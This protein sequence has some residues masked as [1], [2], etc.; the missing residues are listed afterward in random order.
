[1]PKFSTE[2]YL[3]LLLMGCLF[4]M[5]P[6]LS[7]DAG[8][9]GDEKVHMEQA[10]KVL[11][12]FASFSQ[13]KSAVHTPVTNLSHYG[14][15]VDNITTL[16]SEV[17]QIEDVYLF[18][19]LFNS[20]LAWLCVLFTAL[21][22]IH[23]SGYGAAMV[24]VLLLVLSPRF[25][26][27]SFNNLKD[28]PFAL[29][30]IASLYYMIKVN[31]YLPHIRLKDAVG[32]IFSMAFILS[33]RPGGL[34]VF[35]YFIG[36]TGLTF[37]R[38]M[39]QQTIAQSMWMIIAGRTLAICFIAYFAGLLFWPYALENPFRHPIKAMWMM[40]NYPVVLRQLFEGEL[41]WSDQLPWYYLIKY[42]AI[43]IPLVVLPLTVVFMVML[44][45][46]TN[47]AALRVVKLFLVFT[48]LFPLV[49]TIYA[50][51]NVYG[52]WRHV[53][54]IYPPL[55]VM[56]S[57]GLWELQSALKKKVMRLVL[58]G[59]VMFSMIGP[60]RFIYKNHPIEY[61][62]FNRLAGSYNQVS[63]AYELDYYYHSVGEA[64]RWLLDYIETNREDSITI[65]SSYN[66]DDYFRNASKHIDFGYVPYY[67]RGNVKWDYAIFYR[68]L[69]L[70]S[71]MRQN[72][73]PPRGTI[74]T[75][76][77]E[78]V[79]VC[80]VVKRKDYSDYEGKVA[81]EKGQYTKAEALLKSATDIDPANEIAWIN[82]GK[83]YVKQHRFLKANEAFNQCLNV[84]V[85]YEPA[86]FYLAKT[87]TLLF[88]F[89]QAEAHYKRI[90]SINDRSTSAYFAFAKLQYT[91][92]EKEEALGLLD[93]CLVQKPKHPEALALK[94]Q[95]SKELNNE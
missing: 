70:P 14:Q 15:S 41:Y 67:L 23:L 50:Q 64:S 45:K 19:H 75:I 69:T 54:F 61:T 28:I 73:W 49:Y 59:L 35:C 16:V 37:L 29:G 31:K 38:L 53:L 39:K 10:H 13:D 21:L 82:L 47:F 5:M 51:S 66:M 52:G 36:F 11:H 8:I 30:Y 46:K 17:F 65:A 78:G 24:T 57:V 80:V 22:A 6:L 84:I 42:I 74:K 12:Y 89:D 48:V 32:L 60:V 94:K 72:L 2:K 83:T 55:V 93:K 43:T 77:V 18:R 85:D 58:L 62:Y 63:S 79:P 95:V 33:I 86:L 44:F 7:L 25:L 56:A 90:L 87:E 68:T 76:T 34:L 4:V 3:F 1:M 71:Q 9:S 88:N 20:I 91:Q 26:G 92:G 81:Y 27:H 40:S